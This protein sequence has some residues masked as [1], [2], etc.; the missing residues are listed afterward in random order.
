M[1]LLFN[2]PWLF[3]FALPLI[4]A[5]LNKIEKIAVAKMLASGD[6]IDQEFIRTTL[7]A[8]VVWAEKKGAKDGPDKFAAVDKLVARALPFLNADQRKKLIEDAVASLDA[9]ANDSLK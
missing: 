3:V 6:A 5:A 9:G 2:H 4:P 7:K 8:A 1:N